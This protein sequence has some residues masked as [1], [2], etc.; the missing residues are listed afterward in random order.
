MADRS[1]AWL[2]LA[3]SMIF[4]ASLAALGGQD[5]SAEVGTAPSASVMPGLPPGSG[6]GHDG[7]SEII[8]P[9]RTV[10]LHFDH[11]L[12]HQL[13]AT[14]TECHTNA[15]T[16]RRASERVAISSRACDR[17]HGTRH[18][19]LTNVQAGE[20]EKGACATCHEGYRAGDG[21]RVRRVAVP[22][23]RLHFSHQVH[24]ARNIGCGQ[25]H[26]AVHRVGEATTSALP[27]MRGCLRCHDLPP[28]SRG[29]AKGGCPTC[30]LTGPS[31]TLR[32]DYPEG[33]L[34]PPRWLRAA[35]H[36]PDFIRTHGPAAANDS[37]F[38]AQC[39]S[40]ASCA[41]CHD[42]RVRPRDIH[43]NDFLSMHS[44]AAKQSAQKCGSCHRH[45]T[46]CKTCHMRAGVTAT[47]PSWNRLQQGR[48]HPPPEVFV[49]GPVTGRHH[50]TEARRN[51]PACVG[52]HVERDCVGCHATP[53]GGGIGVNP[54]PA[55]FASRCR[56][57]L[58]RNARPCLVCHEPGDPQ[59]S[60]CR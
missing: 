8:F 46:F 45:E 53:G 28:G 20:G 23:P 47:G 31:G 19:D 33:Q 13:G 6:A 55:G 34:L 60:R 54:H 29:D 9:P 49:T 56:S 57:A 48:I 22:A 3:A 51:L 10:P 32:T 18:E 40:E 27:R 38:C 37:K 15:K 58:S 59:L 52:C 41:R 30:H 35:E 14:C 4:G 7:P 44:V 25:C 50:A 17:C 5:A 26:G 2:V 43:P 1:H 12:H 36:G 42:G 21:N 39:H 11:A 16:S 24:A